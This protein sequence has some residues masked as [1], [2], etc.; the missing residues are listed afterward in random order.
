MTDD[1]QTMKDVSHTNPYTG[2]SAGHLFSRGPVVAADG[3][4]EEADGTRQTE[5]TMKD[6]SHTPPYGSSEA[7]RVFERGGREH[8]R[9]DE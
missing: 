6:V 9:G 1:R 2:E 3:G 8:G 5:Q 7:N 4:H